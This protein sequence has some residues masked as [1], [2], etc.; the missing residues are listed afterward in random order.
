V[1]CWWW[2]G[3]LYAGSG[4]TGNQS[5]LTDVSFI[6]NHAILGGGGM[7]N[8]W[9]NHI[10]TNVIFS[11]NTTDNLGGAIYNSGNPTLTNATFSGNKADDEGG[12]I[13]N[14][15]DQAQP[16]PFFMPD[17]NTNEYETEANSPTA[18][19]PGHQST[20]TPT[21]TPSDVAINVDL[22]KQHIE[23]AVNNPSPTPTLTPTPE[24]AAEL[25]PPKQEMAHSNNSASNPILQKVIFW[26]N[27]DSSG[28]GTATFANEP[29]VANAGT[30]QTVAINSLV[31]LDGSNSADSDPGQT[32]SYGFERA[33]GDGH[34][35]G[36]LRPA[37][38][39]GA[40]GIGERK[41]YLHGAG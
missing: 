36:R 9:G 28:V 11:G 24:P 4:G 41:R 1:Y 26:N 14:D 2:G 37:G 32:L 39:T 29:P 17:A 20:P 25:A 38:H 15:G 27:E 6:G 30:D 5:I 13:Y 19:M 10:L 8:W 40:R 18:V 35:N 21:P 23:T 3:G 31:V 33:N 7:A 22:S 16:T 34:A 12:A